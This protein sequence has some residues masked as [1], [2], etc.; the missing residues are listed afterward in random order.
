MDI[1]ESLEN[2]NVSEECFEDIIN[3]VECYLSED[4]VSYI[5]KNYSPY[6]PKGQRLMSKAEDAKSRGQYA[7]YK[8]ELKRIQDNKIRK[9]IHPSV[10]DKQKQREE[11]IDNFAQ[12]SNGEHGEYD[13]RVA[14][15]I[16]QARAEGRDSKSLIGL[17]KNVSKKK[18][19]W[20]T[21]YGETEVGGGDSTSQTLVR[22]TKDTDNY[23]YGKSDVDAENNIRNSKGTSGKPDK[24]DEK[25]H[26]T[27]HDYQKYKKIATKALKGHDTLGSMHGDHKAEFAEKFK[28]EFPKAH[29]KGQLVGAYRRAKRRG[30]IDTR[31]W[32]ITSSPKALYRIG[33]A[34][35]NRRNKKS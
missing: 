8:K 1:F 14:S 13:N 26:A 18:P 5:E 12:K 20:Y 35:E 9:D 22:S 3:I 7:S 2:L 11:D 33:K 21:D 16:A 17:D 4:T 24:W 23:P 19:T 29:E 10:L 6:D 32:P 34:I 31:P 25:G 28:E 30:D 15:K 27:L